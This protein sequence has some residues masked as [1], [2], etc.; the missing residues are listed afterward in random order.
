MRY[1]FDMPHT[2]ADEVTEFDP[3]EVKALLDSGRAVLIDVREPAE[4][5]AERIP[6][7]LLYPL[8]TFDA[9]QLPP[10]GPRMVVFHC[11]VGGRSMV[12]AL[13]RIGHGQ[14]GA[15]M[16]GG[17]SEWKASGLPT[18]RMDLRTGRPL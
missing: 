14:P 2:T 1:I 17:I 15:H 7:A 4:Y 16:T 6:G 11:A 13:Q 5:A 12:A 9:T 18:I 3:E 10:D 8:S